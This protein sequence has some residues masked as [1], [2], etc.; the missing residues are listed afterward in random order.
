VKTSCWMISAADV[1]L[2]Q[3][4]LKRGALVLLVLFVAACDRQISQAQFQYAGLALGTSFSV[5]V[6]HKPVEIDPAWLKNQIDL[7][8]EEVDRSMS[9]YRRDSELS[10]FNRNPTTDW[11]P[12]SEALA[13][14]VAES[15]EISRWSGGAFDVTVGPLVN[16]WG[17]GPDPRTSK[18]PADEKIAAAMARIGYDKLEVRLQP[19][20]LAKRIPDLYVD[21]SAI[22]KGYAVDNVARYLETLG[23]RDYMV[24]I[25]GELRLKG[26]SPRGGPW[27]IA[28]E[29][30]VAKM[31]E[32]EKVLSLT[33]IS[34]ATSGDYRNYFESEGRRFSHTIDPRTGRP[35][36]HRLASVT[37]LSH[38]TRH[39]DAMATALMVLGPEEGYVKAEKENIKALFI[40]KDDDGFVERA[41]SALTGYLRGGAS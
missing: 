28:I 24:E 6:S 20:A 4:I 27:R 21:L 33:D 19:P 2:G 41:T 12:V 11:Q 35:I 8:I 22:A 5:K 40:V 14:L 15:L 31:R 1:L 17:F 36:T 13:S 39:A 7:K 30:P 23:I 18:A 3:P 34:I 38:T 10:R 16:L 25:G 29:K 9:T 37:V 26:L 32:V